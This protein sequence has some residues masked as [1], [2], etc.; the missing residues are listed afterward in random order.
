MHYNHHRRLLL[1]GL[2][3]AGLGLVAA[4][5]LSLNSDDAAW[6]L[7][8]RVGKPLLP[9][10]FNE[11]SLGMSPKAQAAAKEAVVKVGNRYPDAPVGRLREMLAARN[12]VT[13]E[14][15]LFGNGSSELL[16]AAV[17]YM[18]Q[19]GATVVEPQPTFGGLRSYAKTFG[20]KV[21]SVPVGEDFVTDINALRAKAESVKGPVLVNICNPN[22]PTGAIVDDKLMS[23]WI[24]EAPDNLMFLIDEAYFEYADNQPG[25]QSALPH[26]LRGKE[27]ILLTRTFSKIYGMAGMRIGYGIAAPKT[28]GALK[29]FSADWNINVAGIA[30]AIASLQDDAFFRFS[31]DSNKQA[32]QI[33][34]NTLDELQL[35][36]V[37]GHSNFVLHK[38]NS[39]LSEYNRRMLANNIK[40]GR[41]M[42]RQDDWNRLSIGTPEQMKEFVKVLK[43]FREKGWV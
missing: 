30:A 1:K 24:E 6:Q 41:P 15:I 39:N 5:V 21:V 31:L 32:K 36:Y 4:P 18:A 10:H 8:E 26:I 9:L 42:T 28:A 11:N 20:L 34:V 35:P 2:A 33:L 16:G 14:Q 19:K 37:Q 40:V 7:L 25:Y 3:A 17:A 29:N 23:R 43:I 22:N 12:N 38:I 13:T 27:N